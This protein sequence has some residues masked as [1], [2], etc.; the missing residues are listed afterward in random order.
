MLVWFDKLFVVLVD[1]KIFLWF[2]MGVLIVF[3]LVEVVFVFV[4]DLVS[5]ILLVSFN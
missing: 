4:L 1:V 5:M 3:E 2:Y